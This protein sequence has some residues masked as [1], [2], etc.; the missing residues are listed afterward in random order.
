[1]RRRASRLALALLGVATASAFAQLA[2]DHPDWNEGEVPP[3]PAFD[4]KRLVTLDMPRPSALT[5]GIDP[6]TLSIGRDGIVRY[7][8]VAA[9]P[10]GAMNVMYEGIRCTTAQ[11]RVYA[12]YHGDSGWTPNSQTAWQ[13]LH[14]P[15][16][17]RHPLYLARAGVCTGAAPNS[18]VDRI[19]RSLT[20]PGGQRYDREGE[21][22]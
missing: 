12:R 10:S 18:S 13:S 14:E 2:A 22:P 11:H 1:M 15:M 21:N 16:R 4:V 6:A 20:N 8:V 3:P 19:V 7:V 9:S 5:I 17:S